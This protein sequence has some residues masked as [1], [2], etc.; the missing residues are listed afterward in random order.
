MDRSRDLDMLPRQL[1]KGGASVVSDL[2]PPTRRQVVAGVSSIGALAVAGTP[3]GRADAQVRPINIG[4]AFSDI[5]R[6]W[7]GPEGGFQGVRVAGYPIYDALIN[8]DLSSADRPSV[9]IPGLAESWSV[10]AS[11]KTRWIVKLRRGVKFHDGSEFDAEAAVWNFS[12]VLDKNAPQY[13]APRAALIG[14]RLPSVKRAEKIDRYTIAVF[15][16]GTDAM[17]PYQ[18]SFLLMVSPAQYAKLGGDWNRFAA[19]PSGTGP[20]A[21]AGLVARKRLDLTRNES[22]WDTRRIPKSRA[23]TLMPIL[24][25]NSRLA[26]L[27]SGQVDLAE[28]M[29]SEALASLRSA[30]FKVDTTIYPAILKWNF[31][32]VQNSPLRD[33]R[34]RKAANLAID[35]EGLVQLLDGTVVAAKSYVD[36]SSPWFAEGSF[37]LAYDPITAKSLLAAAGFGPNKPLKLTTLIASDGNGQMSLAT[38]EFI[39]ANLAAV[40][41]NVEFKVVDFVTMLTIARGG[42]KAPASAGIDCMAIPGPVLDPTSFFLR[43]FH[44]A[45]TPPKGSNWGFYS[46][47]HVDAALES[48]REAFEPAALNSAIAAVNRLMVDDAASLLI[49][50]EVT[51]WG[52]SSEVKNFVQARNWFV[53]LTGVSLA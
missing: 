38:N 45:L 4:I 16:D 18:L 12:S 15:T 11:E 34:V 23:A 47:P 25:A 14:F 44:S 27:R 42:A 2:L 6:L 20:F 10:D 22:Y 46:N 43:G 48:A 17:T 26:A 31:S 52:L 39:Q 21:V 51:C 28:N 41:I 13:Y 5:P 37:K 33:I 29:P 50:I 3:V 8:W 9:L 36:D 49:A 32:Y 1:G 35:R 53:D 40:G 24:D 7:G 30:G 19:S